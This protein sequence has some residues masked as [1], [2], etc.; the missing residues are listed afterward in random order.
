MS[1][2]MP[3]RRR[4]Q[5]AGGLRVQKRRPRRS[6][7]TGRG[8]DE[9]KAKHDSPARKRS[10]P[11]SGDAAWRL[12]LY[13]RVEAREVLYSFFVALGS[14]ALEPVSGFAEVDFRA[15]SVPATAAKVILRIGI[16]LIRRERVI[17]ERFFM[18]LL[19]VK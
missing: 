12:R 17:P 9:A 1:F 14:S 3:P 11:G 16:A 2:S 7:R 18:F 5:L 15:S 19:R 8:D 4:R 6:A 13:L 10:I